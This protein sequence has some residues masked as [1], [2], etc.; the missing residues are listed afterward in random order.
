MKSKGSFFI[1]LLFIVLISLTVVC[2]NENTTTLKEDNTPNVVCAN[3]NTTTLT[4]DNTPDV[5]CANENTTTLTEDNVPSDVIDLEI[6]ISECEDVEDTVDF[7]WKLTITN[8][9]GISK[10]TAVLTEIPD[11][12]KIVAYSADGGTFDL[13]TNVW[14][15]GDL[16]PNTSKTIQFYGMFNNRL[17]KDNYPFDV[18][19][20][21]TI[22]RHDRDLSNNFAIQN[23]KWTELGGSPASSQ[24]GKKIRFNWGSYLPTYKYKSYRKP[25]KK[26]IYKPVKKKAKKKKR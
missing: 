3:E 22:N 6:L 16:T 17:V 25:V 2:A 15:V 5:V 11:N 7:S 20:D 21:A 19:A 18:C 13:V 12:V 14:T 23:F 4:E 8:L 24:S 1:A 10:N 26:V 9:N